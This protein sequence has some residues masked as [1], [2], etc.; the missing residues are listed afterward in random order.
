MSTQTEGPWRAEVLVYNESKWAT[1][2]LRFNSESEAL[3]YGFDLRSR[4]TMVDKVRAVP[5]C[6]PMGMAYKPGS[7]AAHY[8]DVKGTC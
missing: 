8:Q 7:E 6:W 2:A 1:N 5:D 3:S 4:W